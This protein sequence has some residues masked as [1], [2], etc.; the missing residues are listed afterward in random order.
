[1]E[2][3]ITM[4]ASM[5]LIKDDLIYGNPKCNGVPTLEDCAE[6]NSYLRDDGDFAYWQC[7]LCKG[8]FIVYLDYIPEY[9]V[10]SLKE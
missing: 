6:F 8:E 5:S 3:E 4:E 2:E 9:H 1:M 10:E 7:P